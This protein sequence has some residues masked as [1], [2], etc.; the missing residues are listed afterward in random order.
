MPDGTIGDGVDDEGGRL[1]WQYAHECDDVH[2]DGVGELVPIDDDAEAKQV[3]QLDDIG[4]RDGRDL[5]RLEGPQAHKLDEE[6][7][8]GASELVCVDDAAHDEEVDGEA[9]EEVEASQVM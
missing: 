6:D 1:E 3:V 9:I 7:D 5:D 4:D 2:D 8:S